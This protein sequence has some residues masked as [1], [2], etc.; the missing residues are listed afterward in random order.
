MWGVIRPKIWTVHARPEQ[1]TWNAPITIEYDGFFYFRTNFDAATFAVPGAGKTYYVSLTGNDTNDGLTLATAFRS[2]RVAM[3]KADVDIVRVAPGV[4]TRNFGM[5]GVN[6]NNRNVMIV[7]SAPGRV[8]ITGMD[9]FTW[10][11]T[12]GRTATYQVNRSSIY[13]VYDAKYLDRWG[14]HQLLTA[15][16]SI[17]E[18]DANPGSYYTDGTIVYVR[19]S[20]SRQPD[21]NVKVNMS[22][23]TCDIANAGKVYMENI[24]FEGGRGLFIQGSTTVASGIY[25]KSVTSKYGMARD[26][27]FSALEI[28][29]AFFQ[30]CVAARSE[31]DGFNYHGVTNKVKAIE[32]NCVGRHNGIDS[33]TDNGS[34]MHDGGSIIRINCGFWGNKGPNVA[35]VT[36]GTQSWN[37]GCF[38]LEGAAPAANTGFQAG[39][40]SGG[41][42][43]AIYEG[44][45]AYGSEN[46][47]VVRSGS[48]AYTGNNRFATESITGT[49]IAI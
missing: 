20:D 26:G 11:K 29:E 9:T 31:N 43:T 40:T 47:F 42:I 13:N 19:T 49:K 2:I 6:L 17:A 28:N 8:V 25:C 1:F 46:D 10:T 37:M 18:V 33:N 4:Y 16:T 48:T 35:D 44:C 5:N 32:V 3:N 27:G 45:I 23:S 7:P 12:T 39:D 22:V 41:G 36:A 34:T 30:D 21:N 38:A 24:D 15:R 14:D